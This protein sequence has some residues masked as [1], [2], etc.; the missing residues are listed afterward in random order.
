MGKNA[1]KEEVNILRLEEG[2][3]QYCNDLWC[4]FDCIHSR[5]ESLSMAKITIQGSRTHVIH[6]MLTHHGMQ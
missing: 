4:K 2:H 6:N 5:Q 3:W 1:A